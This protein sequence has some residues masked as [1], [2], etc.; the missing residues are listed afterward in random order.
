MATGKL[1]GRR[2]TDRSP[3]RWN[4]QVSQ[5]SVKTAY[6]ALHLSF[7][8]EFHL[9]T[10]FLMK[11]KSYFSNLLTILYEYRTGVSHLLPTGASGTMASP[12]RFY[13]EAEGFGERKVGKC[14]DI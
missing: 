14:L 1:Q 11:K 7:M 6:A 12:I 4:D 8:V 5:A 2:S 9:N 13:C 10:I 3:M